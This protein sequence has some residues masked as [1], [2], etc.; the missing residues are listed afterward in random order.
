MLLTWFEICNSILEDLANMTISSSAPLVD[1]H[2][3][4]HLSKKKIKKKQPKSS[5]PNKKNK[6]VSDAKNNSASSEKHLV[7]ENINNGND[8]SEDIYAP[9]D[10]YV[11]Y[12]EE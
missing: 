7:N 12:Y 5:I 6:F 9:K 4:W 2:V 10:M 11:L 1:E 8:E 3:T